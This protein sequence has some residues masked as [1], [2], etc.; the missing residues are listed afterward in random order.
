ME[1]E[2]DINFYNRMDDLRSH[3]T[4]LDMVKSLKPGDRILIEVTVA[5]MQ[6]TTVP[7]NWYVR[8]ALN[9]SEDHSLDGEG[10]IRNEAIH[11]V[12]SRAPWVANNATKREI[13]HV[14][15]SSY[16]HCTPLR[17]WGTNPT[18]MDRMELRRDNGEI[19]Q[20]IP[21]MGA[22]GRIVVDDPEA[23]IRGHYYR[24]LD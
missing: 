3:Y 16:E 10:N 7:S 21:L 11:S 22:W 18:Q 20:A 14:G 12:I 1:Y 19:I 17:Y 2:S 23:F 24:R 13:F 8:A 9:G 4:Q 15:P 5:E 6:D